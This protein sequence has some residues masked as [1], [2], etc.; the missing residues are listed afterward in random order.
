MDTPK[1]DRRV[2]RTKKLLKQGLSELMKE[3]DFK[4]ISV[5]DIT[6]RMDL[7]RGTFYL[8]YTDIYDLLNKIETDVLDDFQRVIDTYRQKTDKRSLLP[9]IEPLAAYI[10][11]NADICRILFLNK[12]STDFSIKLKNLIITNGKTLI[13]ERFKINASAETINY[14]LNYMAYGIIGIMKEWLSDFNSIGMNEI[15]KLSDKILYSTA[16]ALE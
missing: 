5:K 13:E 2:R 7:N 15:I 9:V 6:D 11:E 3:K 4:D 16:K 12:A 14:L 1:E 8:H 10:S